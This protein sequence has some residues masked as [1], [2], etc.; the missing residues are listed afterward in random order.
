MTSTQIPDVSAKPPNSV[1]GSV[2]WSVIGGI[3]TIGCLV[4]W[5]LYSPVGTFYRAGMA[6]YKEGNLRGAI[7]DYTKSIEND[8]D[9]VNAY[10]RRGIAKY[11]L[12][13]K[14]GAIADYTIALQKDDDY[15]WAY[16]ERGLAEY[17][18]GDM[19]SAL[20]DYN[21]AIDNDNPIIWRITGAVIS[22]PTCTII[23]EQ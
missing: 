20:N 1:N 17:A 14:R 4:L 2:V 16:Y 15:S 6:K 19:K 9:Y 23:K 10:I 5:E 21:K 3:A 13:D 8:K 11:D 7:D 18:L 12:G 22:N